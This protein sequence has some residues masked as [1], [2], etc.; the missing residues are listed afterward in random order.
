MRIYGQ[1]FSTTTIQRIQQ[2]VTLEPAISRRDLSNRVC[3]WMNWRSPNGQL[4]DMSCRKALVE[5]NRKGIITL[6]TQE[7]SFS[8]SNAT[9]L[10]IE[11][12]ISHL[13]CDLS[14]VGE[15][16]VVPVT[17]RYCKDSKIWR[18]LLDRYHYLGSGPLCG[19]QIRYVIKSSK[20]GYL[21]ALAFSSA[22]W[23]LKARDKYIGWSDLSRRAN[24]PHVVGNDRFLILPTVKVKNLASHVL[25]LAISRLPDDWQ[26]RYNIRPVLVET[27]VNPDRFNGTCYRAA[28]WKSIG[29]TAGR[30]DGI[31]KEVF[32]YQLCPHWRT[33][34]C[35][36]PEVRLGEASGIESPANWAEREFG[37]A[38]LYDNRLKQ[39]LYTIAQDFYN[40]PQANIPEACGTQAG[41]IGAYRF[42]NNEKV[43]MDII[44]TSHTEA[45]IERIREHRIVLAPQDTSTLN[46]ATHP[47][48]EGMGPINNVDNKAI[49]LI[50]HDTMAFTEDGTPLGILD[51]QCWARDPDD[52]G[53]AKC[54]KQLPIEQ[55]ESMK[56]LRSFQRVAE[57]QKLCPETMLVSIGDRESDIYELFLESAKEETGPELLI[58]AEKSR[59]R[60]V[61]QEPLWNF[62]QKRQIVGSL[63][64]HIPHSGSRKARNAL[65]DISFAEVELTP[66][67]HLADTCNPVK[68]WAVHA[69][70]TDQD[71]SI[72]SPIEWM[73]LTTVPVNTFADAKQRVEWYSKRWGIEVYHRTLKSGC[74]IKDRQLGTADRI[75]TCL[76]IDMVVAWR[77]FHL[78]M[79][80]RETPDAPCTVF[81]KEIE[82]KSLCCYVSK[83][84]IP[85][86]EP[87]TLLKA[88]Y[89]VGSIGGHL[90]RKRDGPPGT[91]TLWRG[92][93]RLDTAT[94]MYS[95]LTQPCSINDADP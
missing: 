58:R 1:Q 55:K 91:Q 37:S 46:Y 16:M 19:A 94:E 59:N 32:L 72:D 17:S 12:D 34:L 43:T 56:W 27:F 41:T 6:P 8:F 87:P 3:N 14:D 5:L 84:P 44:L 31:K 33:T 75:E 85:P 95:I 62:M 35:N 11:F 66:P 71:E 61:E 77:I 49:G 63:Q 40:K 88:I 57:V 10:D 76:G 64:V 9:D 13:C 2:T 86:A 82:W 79:L 51:A 7:S 67:K 54:R 73:L 83:T 36:E 53:K 93:Q 42:F 18:A 70:E 65:V 74:R 52:K 89:M 48:T 30:R 47:M 26:Q 45:T 4:Q 29:Y 23:A 78:T 21:G 90:G 15:I 22:T 81:F 69:L 50:L 60:K 25:S 68:V 80:G 92:L 20:Y 38:G 39:R 28:N 24:L